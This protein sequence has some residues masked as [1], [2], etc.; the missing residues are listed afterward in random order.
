MA[1]FTLAYRASNV[2]TA[3]R[4]QAQEVGT[5]A[6]DYGGS[7]FQWATSAEE[8]TQLWAAR[9]TAYWA[10]LQLRPGCQ[11]RVLSSAGLCCP[12]SHVTSCWKILG[13]T[14][15]GG[16]RSCSKQLLHL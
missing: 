10:A 16:F 2:V 6:E 11:V 7:S 12:L 5:V 3:W 4:S 9:H 14:V 15:C 8:R 1:V 13:K